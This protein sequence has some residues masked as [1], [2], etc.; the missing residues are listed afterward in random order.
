MNDNKP[1]GAIMEAGHSIDADGDL[2]AYIAIKVQSVAQAQE[3][4][5]GL[6][7]YLRKVLEEVFSDREIETQRVE[8]GFSKQ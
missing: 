4:L 2:I 5:E 7:P 1:R 6:E 8:S 3:V